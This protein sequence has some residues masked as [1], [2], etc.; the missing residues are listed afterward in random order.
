M[1]ES[2][3][4]FCEKYLTGGYNIKINKGKK[5]L[6]FPRIAPI[7]TLGFILLP[8]GIDGEVLAA[9]II[10]YVLLGVGT[11]GFFF[12]KLFPNRRKKR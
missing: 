8:I 11:F 6:S 7:M 10:S 4:K 2:F 5:Y 12:Y 9:E 1:K 3:L